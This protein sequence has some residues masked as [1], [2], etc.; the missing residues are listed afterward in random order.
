MWIAIKISEDS[1]KAVCNGCMLPPNVE[2]VVQGIKNGTV[3]PEGWDDDTC[4]IEADE[5][6][7]EG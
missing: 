2:E 3:F 4:W 5:S 1:Y 7:S 6:E